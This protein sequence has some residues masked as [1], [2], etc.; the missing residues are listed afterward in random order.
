MT[1]FLFHAALNA[2][3]NFSLDQIRLVVKISTEFDFPTEFDFRNLAFKSD[4]KKQEKE[5]GKGKRTATQLSSVL[6][7][8]PVFPNLFAHLAMPEA[9]VE[10]AGREE[11]VM[12]EYQM[13]PHG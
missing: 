10:P 9:S 6:E 12:C 8:F 11:D 1:F 7:G 13:W 2:L 4:R 5:E 3:S